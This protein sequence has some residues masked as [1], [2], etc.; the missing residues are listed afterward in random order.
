MKLTKLL[1][2]FVCAIG[3]A[4]HADA[5]T[6]ELYQYGWDAGGPLEIAFTGDDLN[7]NGG[8]DTE[9]LLSFTA[10]F[11]L[12]GGGNAKLFLPDIDVGE[13]FYA[14]SADY[15]VN[16]G[17]SIFSLYETVFPGGSIAIFSDPTTSFIALSGE[18]FREA[19]IPE[20][21]SAA[22]LGLGVFFTWVVRRTAR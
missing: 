15:F 20:P 3:A 17:N 9:E 10:T 5:A 7:L 14:S 4:A 12:P 21:G 2:L 13:F 1:F 6:F 19:P 18:P 11:H 16:A 8:I 22:L